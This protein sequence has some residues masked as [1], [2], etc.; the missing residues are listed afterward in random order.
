MQQEGENSTELLELEVARQEREHSGKRFDPLK[1]GNS[2][3]GETKEKQG[4]LARERSPRRKL[5]FDLHPREA[6]LR[7]LPAGARERQ[8]SATR[9]GRE[10]QG[11]IRTPPCL[12]KNL[13]G[14]A[15]PDSS[16]RETRLLQGSVH[17]W[18]QELDKEREAMGDKDR[19]TEGR[20]VIGN[21]QIEDQKREEIPKENRYRQE[22]RDAPTLKRSTTMHQREGSRTAPIT[23]SRSCRPLHQGA[24][25]EIQGTARNHF[26]PHPKERAQE[27]KSALSLRGMA[28]KTLEAVFAWAL[29]LLGVAWKVLKTAPSWKEAQG[30]LAGVPRVSRRRKNCQMREGPGKRERGA[31]PESQSR[32][33]PGWK[34]G[35]CSSGEQQGELDRKGSRALQLESILQHKEAALKQWQAGARKIQDSAPSLGRESQRVFL[36]PSR[37][38]ENLQLKAGLD[39]RVGERWLLQ[40]GEASTELLQREAEISPIKGKWKRAEEAREK[41]REE[42]TQAEPRH[43]KR[44]VKMQSLTDQRGPS[45]WKS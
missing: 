32:D 42:G 9:L 44:L 27:G 7:Q 43:G 15:N 39:S 30:A 34:D 36:D 6:A 17:S 2:R 25:E 14:K 37:L 35:R 3:V 18:Q 33:E 29:S 21:L 12:K 13:Q 5:E 22:E 8:D 23:G 41:R 1:A 45:T 40:G 31:I 24:G 11:V 38:T 4:K 16:I 10:L 26:D 19:R 28:R 20:Q